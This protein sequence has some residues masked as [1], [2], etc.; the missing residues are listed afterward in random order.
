MIGGTGDP[1]VTAIAAA[2]WH[3]GAGERLAAPH[4]PQG[5]DRLGEQD[6]LA[7]SARR[8]AGAIALDSADHS[9]P[10]DRAGAD[11][12]QTARAPTTAAS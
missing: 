8:R 12:E 11:S 10:G 5:V 6:P 3:V 2:T 9:L 7:A 4:R 1:S